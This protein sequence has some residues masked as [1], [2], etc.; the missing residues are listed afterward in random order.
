MFTNLNLKF[1]VGFQCVTLLRCLCILLKK[2]V[3]SV[4]MINISI[5]TVKT[6][7]C[8]NEQVFFFRNV[9]NF[10]QK[11]YILNVHIFIMPAVPTLGVKLH[12]NTQ[13]G[14]NQLAS[15]IG[16]HNLSIYLISLLQNGTSKS[17]ARQI[18][19]FLSFGLYSD[20]TKTI[21]CSVGFGKKIS[22]GDPPSYINL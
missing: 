16:V 20:W 14:R 18:K 11:K 2:T 9:C 1:W 21:N 4:P 7:I 22:N 6:I 19:I 5:R 3:L 17:P 13:Y 15:R 8:L 10:S 12:T